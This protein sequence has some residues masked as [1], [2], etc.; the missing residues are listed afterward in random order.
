MISAILFI[1]TKGE[2][3]I[4]RFYK[5]DVT[6]A[7]ADAFRMQVV[8]A[9]DFGSPVMYIDGCTFVY[10]RNGDMFVVGMT[11][12][13]SNVVLI[14]QY[15]FDL[16]EVFREYFGAFDEEHLKSNF[17]L[18]YELLDETMDY[19][20]PQI[21]TTNLLSQFIKH[22]KITKKQKKLTEQAGGVGP[23]ITSQITGAIDWRQPGKYKYRKNEVFIDV[24]ESVN[25]LLSTKRTVLSSDV[26]GKIVMKTYLTG[27][28]ECKFGMNDKVLL[29]NEAKVNIKKA[30]RPMTGI[31]ID[32]FTFHRAVRLGKF[33]TDRTISFIPP[34]GTFD[35]MK[36]RITQN[37]NLPFQVIPMISEMGNTRVEYEI[38]VKG[39]FSP[40][41]SAVQVAMRIPCPKNT[42]KCKVKVGT[43]RWKYNPE[44]ATILW[45]ISKFRGGASYIMRGEVT[46]IRQIEEESWSRPPITMDFQV[47]MYTS[48]GLHVR[49]LKVT[50]KSNYATTK[51]VRYI[52]RAGSYQIRI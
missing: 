23:Q 49:F 35:L 52:T 34:D 25:I 16:V 5:D 20:Y 42:S 44:D 12:Q 4:S 36:Y 19:G 26:S 31:A 32:D 24:L 30:A 48:S 13:N 11:L 9:K 27:M 38:K 45:K 46:L 50:E 22:G 1:N 2:I 39:N 28:P 33:D 10:I 51:W 43:G 7:H 37:I 21:V 6:R 18:V 47:P 8:A 29:E 41:L 14:Q 40:K 3:V 17:V 15:M